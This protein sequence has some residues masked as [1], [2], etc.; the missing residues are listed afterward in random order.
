MQFTAFWKAKGGILAT[1]PSPPEVRELDNLLS[2]NPH[3]S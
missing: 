2:I 1:H 3:L